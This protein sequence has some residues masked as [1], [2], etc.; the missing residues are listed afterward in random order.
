ME[1][2]KTRLA[3]YD[4]LTNYRISLDN[5]AATPAES[6]NS[7]HLLLQVLEGTRSHVA[8]LLCRQATVPVLASETYGGPT[9]AGAHL[10]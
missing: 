7:S 6:H 1:S 4:E 8:P 5:A 2:A 10:D 3:H 9:E